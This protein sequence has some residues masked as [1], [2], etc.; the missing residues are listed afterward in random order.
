MS[1][2]R[3]V[4]ADSPT[5]YP[6]EAEV[7]RRVLPPSKASEWPDIA[8]VLE[9]EGLPQIDPIMGGRYW[10]AVKAFLDRRHG[11][12]RAGVPATAD[13]EEIWR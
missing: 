12:R 10:P 2:A 4:P 13:G 6:S 9:R 11:L 8:A 3:N 7:A 5:L 1:G